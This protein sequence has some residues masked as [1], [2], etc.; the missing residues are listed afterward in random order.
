MIVKCIHNTSK[1][2]K[3][4]GKIPFGYFE[5]SQ[6]GTTINEHYLVMGMSICENKLLY[7]VDVN[8]SP[9]F[10]PF[11]LFEVID[12]RIPSNWHFRVYI[13]SDHYYPYRQATWGYYEL[14]F[15]DQHV[16]DLLEREEPA[17]RLFYRRKI[18]LENYFKELDSMK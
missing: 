17:M 2:F 1:A 12:S 15:D 14:C 13:P 8:G 7:F 3:D 6:F 18:E 10:M 5:Q 11:Q 4:Y 9:F 16:T